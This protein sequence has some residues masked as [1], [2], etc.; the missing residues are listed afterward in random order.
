[1]PEEGAVRANSVLTDKDDMTEHHKWP[2]MAEFENKGGVWS[3][4]HDTSQTDQSELI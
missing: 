4:A 1:M 3:D 2:K